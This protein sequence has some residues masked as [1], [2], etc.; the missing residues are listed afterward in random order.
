MAL[1]AGAVIAALCGGVALKKLSGSNGVPDV[2]V[3]LVTQ[4]TLGNVNNENYEVFDNLENK[5]NAFLSEESS[6]LT[7]SKRD[8]TA[9]YLI[10][11]LSFALFVQTVALCLCRI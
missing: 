10:C 3:D 2:N 9:V 6:S 1:A 8:N 5:A 4:L 7:L 11:F